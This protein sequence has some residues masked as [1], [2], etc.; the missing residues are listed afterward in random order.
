MFYKSSKFRFWREAELSHRTSGQV[1]FWSELALGLGYD[2]GA[3]LA[4][5]DLHFG[6]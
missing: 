3:V 4:L 1:E 5:Y 6:L 2:L